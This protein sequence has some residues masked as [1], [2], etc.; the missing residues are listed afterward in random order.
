MCVDALDLA[1]DQHGV[2]GRRR[3]STRVD[4][5]RRAWCELAFTVMCHFEKIRVYLISRFFSIRENYMLANYTWFTVTTV[6]FNYTGS[7]GEIIP[8]KVLGGL[9]F[10]THT[11]HTIVCQPLCEPQLTLTFARH[12]KAHLFG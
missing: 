3:P 9:L 2:V 10:L 8:Q 12:L 4:G 7:P 5:R 6:I 11:V 1:I